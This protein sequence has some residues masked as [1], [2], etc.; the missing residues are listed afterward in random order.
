MSYAPRVEH[1]FDRFS[2]SCVLKRDSMDTHLDTQFMFETYK[3]GLLVFKSDNKS[4]AYL[5]RLS[6]ILTGAPLKIYGAPGNSQGHLTGRWCYAKG[7]GDQTWQ[8]SKIWYEKQ[9][10]DLYN[11]SVN[12]ISII[13]YTLQK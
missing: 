11:M 9:H 13:T 4:I 8:K 5:A 10:F 3:R 2:R 12:Y 6:S 1:T 7:G